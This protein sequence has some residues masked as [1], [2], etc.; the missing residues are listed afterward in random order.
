MIDQSLLGW[1]Q[2][3]NVVY[4]SPGPGRTKEPETRIT[5][6]CVGRLDSRCYASAEGY[7]LGRLK[8]MAW[9]KRQEIAR[10]NVV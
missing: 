1:I 9:G 5:G 7:G 6:P 8:R 2:T 10:K 3:P 4:I